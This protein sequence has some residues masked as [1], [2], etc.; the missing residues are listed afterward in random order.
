[1]HQIRSDL[2]SFYKVAVNSVRGENVMK[3]ALVVGKNELVIKSPLTNQLVAKYDL[4]DR[5]IYLIGAGKSVLGMCCGFLR[6]IKESNVCHPDIKGGILS[7]PHG[8][9]INESDSN[10]LWDNQVKVFHAAKNNIPDTDSVNATQAILDLVAQLPVDES[11]LIVSFISGGGSALLCLPKSGLSLTDKSQVVEQLM[12]SG[13]GIEALNKVRQHLSL[14]KGGQLSE[15]ILR[16]KNNR[17]LS[18][19]ASDIVG[20][21]IEL[22]A[23]GPTVPNQCCPSQEAIAILKT[24]IPDCPEKILKVISPSNEMQD[25]GNRLI[26]LIVVSNRVAVKSAISEAISKGYKVEHAGCNLTGEAKVLAAKW[27]QD[28]LDCEAKGTLFIGGG[29]TVVTIPSDG[30]GVGGRCQEFGLAFSDH[31]KK[32]GPVK[33]AILVA[34]SDGQDGPTPV[35]GVLIDH[36]N[37]FADKEVDLVKET[38]DSHDSYNFISKFRPDWFVNTGGPTGVNVMDLYFM[39]KLND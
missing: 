32:A 9:A 34:G 35:A 37:T 2:L 18:L 29:E 22:I 4:T 10:L 11:N 15:H 25:Y 16:N 14:V 12:K 26:N 19:I 21:P 20:D 1:M 38:L 28:L 8:L 39:V 7:V 13:C 24:Y 31:M 6:T 23:S 30:Q 36:E 27:A 17:L 33:F 5:K 3:S